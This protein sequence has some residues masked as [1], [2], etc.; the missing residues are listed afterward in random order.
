MAHQARAYPCFS[1]QYQEASRSISTPLPPPPAG[2]VV[3][4]GLP[5]ALSSSVPIYTPGWKE[6]QRE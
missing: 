2:M 1:F 6:A 3:I 5:Q 4:T